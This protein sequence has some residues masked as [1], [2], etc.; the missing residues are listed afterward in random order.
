VEYLLSGAELDKLGEQIVKEYLGDREV[1]CLDV[2]DFIQSYLKLPILYDSIA[3]KDVG[4][5]GFIADGKTPLWVNGSNG[6]VQRIYRAGTIVIDKYLLNVQEMG[7]RR[8]TLAHE[9]AHFVLDRTLPVPKA[10]FSHQYD[11]EREYSPEDLSR[12]FGISEWQADTLASTLLMPRKLVENALEVWNEGKPIQ[13]FGQ[14]VT[15][16]DTKMKLRGMA[17]RLGVSISAL[18]IRLRKLGLL[19]NRDLSEYVREDLGLGGVK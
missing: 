4:K 14:T 18:M 17:Y 8:F 6:P 10:A 11:P 12:Q 5:I 2:E 1:R 9:A 19:E 3:E 15:S 7:R 13:I 16:Y